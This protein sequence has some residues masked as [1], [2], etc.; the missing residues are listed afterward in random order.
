MSFFIEMYKSLESNFIYEEGH[1]TSVEEMKHILESDM[2]IE[3]RNVDLHRAVGV[4]FGGRACKT[5]R[6]M[7]GN[8]Y[9]GKDTRKKMYPLKVL[10]VSRNEFQYSFTIFYSIWMLNIHTLSVCFYL[11]ITP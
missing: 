11:F 2:G 6:K 1:F 3:I 4:F 8:Q 10:S 5:S 7:F 9:D